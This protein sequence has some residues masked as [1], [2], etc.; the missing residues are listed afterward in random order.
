MLKETLLR[1]LSAVRTMIAA[2]ESDWLAERDR[3]RRQQ[4]TFLRRIVQ[5]EGSQHKAA[6]ATGISQ[7]V[8][9]RILD[10]KGHAKNRKAGAVRDVRKRNLTSTPTESDEETVP[11][12]VVKLQRRRRSDWQPREPRRPEMYKWFDQ[13]L[14]WTPTAQATARM[15]VLNAG[16]GRLPDAAYHKDDK[17][18]AAT[19]D[20][21]LGPQ[22]GLAAR[23]G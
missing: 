14:E 9:S 21:A 4:A 11:D 5:L 20:R 8:I 1:A 22:R 3:R 13:Y 18:R 12:N 19:S 7:P 15:L 23:G 16:N 6:L 10:P 17:A 2:A